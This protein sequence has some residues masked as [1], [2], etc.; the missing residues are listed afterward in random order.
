MNLQKFALQ[1]KNKLKISFQAIQ[2]KLKDLLASIIKDISL[3]KQIDIVILRENL[4]LYND[5]KLNFSNEALKIFDIK[6]HNLKITSVN[7]N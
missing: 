5:E 6:T 1:E 4:F 3:K 2:R 7:N